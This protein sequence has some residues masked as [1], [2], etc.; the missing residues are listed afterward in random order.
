M[1]CTHCGKHVR[2]EDRFCSHCGAAQSPSAVPLAARRLCRPRKSRM[3]GGV[4]AGF[5]HYMDVDVTVIRIL[6]VF[7]T[8]FTG[9]MMLLAYIVA[10]VLMPEEP[11][12]LAGAEAVPPA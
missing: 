7:T 12:A 8:L 2:S 5:A 9:G 1:Y 4:A 6:L 11:L 3:I 10:W